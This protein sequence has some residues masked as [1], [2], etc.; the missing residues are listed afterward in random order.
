VTNKAAGLLG[1][2]I[3]VICW[4]SASADAYLSNNPISGGIDIAITGEITERDLAFFRSQSKDFEFKRLYVQLNSLGGDVAAAMEIGRII[5]SVDSWTTIPVE[6]RCYSSCALIFIAG[7]VRWNFGQLRLH[8][9]YFAAAPPSR[10]QIEKQMP[11]MRSAVKKYVEEMGIIYR[12]DKSEKIVPHTDPTYDEIST[13]QSAQM[14]GVTTSEYRR[15]ESLAE[16]CSSFISSSMNDKFVDCYESIMWGLSPDVYRSRS[17]MVK[18]R[19]GG[20]WESEINATPIKDRWS[21]PVVVRYYACKLNTM[22]G[23]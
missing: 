17:A 10:E 5:R 2:L 21:L 3:G 18:M 20:F 13:S 11:V 22:L 6:A 1:L 15:R 12:G 9:P 14:H 23:K 4:T 16:S 19:C 8:R 7:V